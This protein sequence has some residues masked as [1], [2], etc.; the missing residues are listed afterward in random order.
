MEDGLAELLADG[1]RAAF[2]GAPMTAVA[3]L[4]Q[5]FERSAAEGRP[6]VATAA[7]WLLGVALGAA[8]RFGSALAVLDPLASQDGTDVPERRLFAALACS[9]AAAVHRQLGQH[10]V[11]RRLDERGLVLAEG[12]A[13]AAFD[14]ELGLA[15]D[16]V[17]LGEAEAAADQLGRARDRAEARSDWWRQRVRLAWVQAEVALLVGDAEAA[18]EAVAPAVQRAEVAGA[19]RHVAKSLLFLG[20]SQIQAG[21]IDEATATL[22]RS[23]TLAEGLGALPLLWPSRAVLGALLEES[24]PA[25]SARCL[26]AARGAVIAIA[27][28]L[29]E[30]LR[31]VWLDREDVSAL[32][33]G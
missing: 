23:A 33:G 19:P 11:A 7:A 30:E 8:G 10:T 9:T 14:A 22:R 32:L 18:I 6:D 13:E 5:A 28:D 26:A 16:A 17:G 24:A 27:D 21:R 2:H 20:V 4:E 12:A 1:E 3:S 31:T 25:E 15:A 29:P